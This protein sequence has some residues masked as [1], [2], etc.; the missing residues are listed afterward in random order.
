VI[1]SWQA[2]VTALEVLPVPVAMTK[3][4]RFWPLGMAS[5]AR[6]TALTW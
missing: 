3:S 5:M 4:T 6:L 1:E 2:K